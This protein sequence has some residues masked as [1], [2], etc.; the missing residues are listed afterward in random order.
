[1]K[2]LFRRSI[3][4]KI[5]GA[6]YRFSVRR[7][8]CDTVLS[9]AKLLGRVDACDRFAELIRARLGLL[10]VIDH[11]RFNTRRGSNGALVALL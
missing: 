5:T 6:G 1:M 7:F 8:A 10:S 2:E 9:R 11:L 3:L 4:V